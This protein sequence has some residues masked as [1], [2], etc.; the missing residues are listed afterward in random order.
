MFSSMKNR[1]VILIQ[2][3]LVGALVTGIAFGQ[4]QD[5]NLVG[6]IMDATGASVPG[7]SVEL[8]N[9]ATGVKTT[10]T[11]DENGFYRFNNVLIGAYKITA[12]AAG[13]TP[14]VREIVIE[15]SKTTT[16]NLTVNVGGITTELQVIESP[17]LIDT[18]TGN[19]QTTFT[20]IMATDLPIGANPIGGGIHN[21]ALTG[22]GVTSSGGVGVG[23]GPSVGGNRPRNNNFTIE[24]ADNN[25]KDVTGPILELPP[26]SIAEYTVLQNQFSAEFGH[27]S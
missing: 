24:G 19:V 1:S 21:L 10:A 27:S 26:D 22:A 13:M 23:F 16:A 3:L 18:T 25:R 14:A 6:L 20:G 17:A 8:Q 7:A 15:L 2:A 4:A 12:S 5:G 11:V 9:L